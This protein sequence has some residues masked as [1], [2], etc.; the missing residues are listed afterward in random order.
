MLRRM[1]HAP[2]WRR[3]WQGGRGL[4]PLTQKNA[5]CEACLPPL[6][7]LQQKVDAGATPC[8]APERRG[9]QLPWREEWGAML[10]CLPLHSPQEGGE[11]NAEK[12]PWGTSALVLF[13]RCLT[14]SGC[15]ECPHHRHVAILSTQRAFGAAAMSGLC[16]HVCIRG[17]Q[18]I[19]GNRTEFILLHGATELFAT[20]DRFLSWPYVR[21][22]REQTQ[23][24]YPH[25]G[26]AK[27]RGLEARNSAWQRHAPK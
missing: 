17:R 8:A 3:I 10:P 25:A 19:R 27:R 6:L 20:L 2:T 26:R 14:S 11:A 22:K 5:A 16:V 18:F 23:T 15:M 4:N 9:G 21:H 24:R 13:S 1:L 12:K 7:S